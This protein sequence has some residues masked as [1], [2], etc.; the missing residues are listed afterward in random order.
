[1]P[2]TNFR[3]RVDG[4]AFANAWALDDVE[5]A[6]L[7]QILAGAADAAVAMALGLAAGALARGLRLG[8][9]V[10]NL[11]LKGVPDALGYCGGMTMA[12]LDYWNKAW[13]V[14]RGDSVTPT[15]ATAEGAV[16]RQYIWG[17]QV[18]SWQENAVR[19]LAWMALAHWVPHVLG[20]GFGGLKRESRQEFDK[21]KAIID[22]GSPCPLMLIARVNDPFQNHQVL[23]Y[24]YADRGDGTAEVYVYDNNCE[25]RES[26]IYLDFTGD[27]LQA[28]F[29]C[30]CTG[31]EMKGFFCSEYHA[32]EPPVAV[33]L[34]AGLLAAVAAAAG[35]TEIRFTVR[36]YGCGPT[37]GIAL[38][39]GDGAAPAL[40]AEPGAQPLAPGGAREAALQIGA[41]AGARQVAARCYLGNVDGA[42]IYK[43]IP[44]V[45][46]GT[47]AM[48]AIGGTPVIR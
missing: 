4:F 24:G 33:G 40:A 25:D 5:R 6:Q 1:M 12:A 14:Q 17:R 44:V 48:V 38:C 31:M 36:N 7:R 32:K 8:K 13:L 30:N 21:L 47:T 46:Q 19:M 43:E 29:S 27:E 20:G 28:M 26:I 42:E 10:A 41:G 3:P 23:A 35:E 37:P 39:V 45:G 18:D 22:G 11:A 15:H 9:K 2:R 34:E 16:L